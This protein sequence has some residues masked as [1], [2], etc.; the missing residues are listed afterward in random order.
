MAPAT[1]ELTAHRRPDKAGLDVSIRFLGLLILVAGCDSGDSGPPPFFV[2]AVDPGPLPELRIFFGHQSVGRDLLTGIAAVAPGLRIVPIDGVAVE[3]GV[4]I[5]TSVGQN[6]HPETKDRAFLDALSR[7]GPLDLALYKYCYI[8]VDPQTDPDRLFDAYA[9]TLDEARARGVRTVPVTLPLTTVEPNWKRWIKGAL[10][11]PTQA[12]L[13]ARRMRFNER[14][15]A[16]FAEQPIVD[17]ARMESTREDGSRCL[18]QL[19]HEPVEY[20]EPGFT[21]DG[22]HLNERGRRHVAA[23]FVLALRAACE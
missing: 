1:P 17:L 14:L 6:Q 12:G 10:G 5:E 22:A 4:L 20:L 8:D 21:Y 15:R 16:H 19:N 11:R 23:A 13:N 9:R 7:T 18:M 3:G 2:E